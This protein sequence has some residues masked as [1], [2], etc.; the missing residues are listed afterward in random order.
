MAEGAVMAITL[1]PTVTSSDTGTTYALDVAFT[2]PHSSGR[3]WTVYGPNGYNLTGSSTTTVNRTETGSAGAVHVWRVVASAYNSTLA[4]T[5][6]VESTVAASVRGNGV[7]VYT[8]G[9]WKP[10]NF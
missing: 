8:S 6:T 2:S 10:L 1:T 3:S 5:E 9:A 7:Y 4:E